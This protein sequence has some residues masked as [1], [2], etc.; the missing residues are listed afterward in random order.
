[1]QSQELNALKYFNLKL[2]SCLIFLTKHDFA[3]LTFILIDFYV[4]N[5]PANE[6][7]GDIVT[8]M[9]EAVGRDRIVFIQGVH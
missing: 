5:R 3:N 7:L 4:I 8:S 6:P 1:M 2:F 9:S